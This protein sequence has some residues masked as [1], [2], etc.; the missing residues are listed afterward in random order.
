MSNLIPIVSPPNDGLGTTIGI[1]PTA[2]FEKAMEAGSINNSSCFLVEISRKD[3]QSWDEIL[4]SA[5]FISNI[6]QAEVSA[7]RINLIDENE[8]TGIDNGS[9]V[10]TGEKYRT[11]NVINPNNT[12]KPNTNYA[13]ILSKD[14]STISVFDSES[15]PGNSGTGSVIFAGPCTSLINDTYTITIGSSG[16][17]N[18]SEYMWT[19]ASDG[20]TSTIIESR[21][22]YANMDQG[23][24]IKFL[25]GSF[26]IGDSFTVNIIPADYQAEI[27]SWNFS[28]GSGEYQEPEDERSGSLIDLPVSGGSSSSGTDSFQ[29]ISIDPPDA[30]TLV[31]I[32]RKSGVT[33]G[34]ITYRTI[35]YTSD[36]NNYTVE[37]LAGGTAGSEVINVVD[38]TKIQITI[39]DGISTAQQIIDAFNMHALAS[40]MTAT[41]EESSA[42][43]TIQ[44]ATQFSKGIDANSIT[45]TFNKDIDPSTV[46]EE[47]IKILTRSI[48]PVG[49]PTSVSFTYQVSG[50]QLVITLKED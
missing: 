48:Y 20:K 22:R 19:R 46:T 1:S 4:N 42:A 27:F 10:D 17:S 34:S 47:K 5:N 31:L 32:A 30:A 33:V 26:T 44:V 3:N 11:K 24:K 12:L 9:D 43:Q 23:I 45:I 38:T 39:E 49:Q 40:A 25:D 7:Q 35:E 29:A 15:N 14:I 13:G 21:G 16:T 36:Y 41:T 28:T 18:T 50:K 37:Y 6:V 2:I 8:Y